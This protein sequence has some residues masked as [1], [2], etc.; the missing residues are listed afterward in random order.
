M[1]PLILAPSKIV[2]QTS[3]S[4]WAEATGGIAVL[5]TDAGNTEAVRAHAGKSFAHIE[6]FADFAASG[7]IERRAVALHAQAPFTA[8]V[9]LSEV[10]VIRSARLRERFGLGGLS[11][12]DARLFRDK[13]AMKRRAVERGIPVTAF[14]LTEDALDV[15]DFVALHGFP[16]VVKPIDGRGSAGV[17]VLHDEAGLDAYLASPAFAHR[18]SPLIERFVR[19]EMYQVNGIFLDGACRLVSTV[20]CINSNLDFLDG[21]Y[22]GLVMLDE[23]DPLRARLV[24][25]GQ[26]LLVEAMPMPADGL[27]HIEVFH[28]EEDDQL[29]LCEVACRLAGCACN[30]QIR[31][32]YEVDVRLEYL[33]SQCL[34]AGSPLRAEPVAAPQRLI[35]ELNIPPSEGVLLAQPHSLSTAGLRAQKYSGVQGRHYGKMAFTNGE[36]ASF[37]IEGRDMAQLVERVHGLAALYSSECAWGAAN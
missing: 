2:L 26:R 1:R 16:V 34:A 7:M 13:Y 25:L 37:L 23:A 15:M 21:N 19:G 20:K 9:P 10:D 18:E 8:V 4:E 24:E 14:A 17:Q 33:R 36:I 32:A 35:A 31:H 30:D 6:T 11:P 12:A 28:A 3:A 27:F 5:F 29:L 22:L